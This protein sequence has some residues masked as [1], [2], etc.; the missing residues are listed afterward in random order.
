MP[1]TPQDAYM[2]LWNSTINKQDSD[3]YGWS[4]NPW[5]WVIGFDRV[6]DY[7]NQGQLFRFDQQI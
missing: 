4:I 1:R 3:K 5:V 6:N 7:E 2:Y